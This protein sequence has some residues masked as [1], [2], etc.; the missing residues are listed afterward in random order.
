MAVGG[1][2]QFRILGGALG[3]SI[4]TNLLN[5]PI[6]SLAGLLPTE[7]IDKLLQSIS[8]ARLLSPSDQALYQAA[9]LDGYQKQFALVLGFAVAEVLA[10]ALM[11][12]WP[13]RRLP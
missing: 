8:A 6:E 11:W 10:L 7:T 9:Y 12:E 3:V 5:G 4:A 1:V 2:T 13:P